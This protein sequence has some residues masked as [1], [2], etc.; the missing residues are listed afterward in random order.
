[1]SWLTVPTRLSWLRTPT[2]LRAIHYLLL[3]V[4][5]FALFVPGLARLPPIDRDESRYMQATSQML[6]SG[7]YVDVRFQDQ[8][9]YLQPAGIYWLEAAS[10]SLLSSAA[11]KQPWAYRIPSQI[12]ATTAVLLTAYVGSTLFGPAAGLA[13]ALLLA[14]SV[15]LG[16]EARMATIDATLL[17]TVMVAQAALMRIFLD[18]EAFVPPRRWLAACYWTALGVGLMLKG[19]VILLVSW[20]TLLGLALAERRVHWW[21]RL[22]P[23]WGVLLMLLIVAPWCIAIGVVSDGT[24]FSRSVGNNFFGKLASGQQAHGLPPGYHLLAFGLAFW[25][26]SLLAVLAAP[27]AWAHRRLPAVR[28][29]L[30]WIVPTWIMFEI[31]VTKLPH[32]VLPTYPAIACL[33]AAAALTASPWRFGRAWRWVTG[34]Y[35]TAWAVLSLG[36][37]LAGA[38][39]LWRVQHAVH[40]APVLAGLAVAAL[41]AAM[42]LAVYRRQPGRSLM[43]GGLA[44]LVVAVSTYGFVLP[45]LQALWLSP[46]IA[47]A[48][49]AVRPCPRS[50]LAST[51][52]SEPSLVFLVGRNTRLVDAESAA[53]L[54]LHDPGCGL[55]LIGQDQAAAFRARMAAA[56]VTPRALAQVGGINYSAQGRHLDL[57]L[58]AAPASGQ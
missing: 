29:L 45:D 51:S 48:V 39:A 33:T 41:A 1:M 55:A 11:A 40:L 53:D 21:R 19:P 36:L 22:Y 34:I 24:F 30:A 20:G 3:A 31:V 38:V 4:M 27:F 12:G 58:Y 42:L 37:A 28:F 32:Y 56:G 16:V 35:G 50:V 43:A 10:V 23:A 54:L 15:L 5:C 2:R 44:S 14:C 13:A 46:R 17:A 9:R 49:R 6:E 47:A 26:G 18:R 25:P 7:N 57:T 8:P 52:Y